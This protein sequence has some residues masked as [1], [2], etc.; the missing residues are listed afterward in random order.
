MDKISSPAMLR[1]QLDRLMGQ[2][3]LLGDHA[4]DST[5]PCTYG[6]SD[7]T[8]R[9]VSES[10]IPK[11]LLAIQEYCTETIPMT[12]DEKL[13]GILQEIGDK[14]REI[15]AAEIEKLCGKEVTQIDIVDWTRDSRKELE[16]FIYSC[17]VPTDEKEST[18]LCCQTKTR[19]DGQTWLHCKR[20]DDKLEGLYPSE[21]TA[22]HDAI[23]FCHTNR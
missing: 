5:C 15:R 8:G 1:W 13:Q 9:Y 3:M 2:L 6:Y 20:N 11:H 14:A 18:F 12:D 19:A 22:H 7:P 17:S 4:S 10:C 16:P 23:E 21:E